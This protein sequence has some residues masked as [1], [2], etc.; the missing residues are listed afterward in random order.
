[1][2]NPVSTRVKRRGR[3]AA[4]GFTLIEV[5]TALFVMGVG[6]TVFVQLYMSSLSISH[7]S[8][9]YSIASQIAE[10]YM[11]ELQINPQQFV[12]P[13]FDDAEVGEL[14]PISLADEDSRLQKV[15]L[16]TV[17][18]ITPGAHER[19]SNL[20]EKFSWT[21]EARI[22]EVDSN[23]VEVRVTINWAHVSRE[24]YFYLTSTV[25]RSVGEGIGL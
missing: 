19:E 10:E 15:A 13:N 18:P 8:T 12:W 20:Y 11:T 6:V 4:S 3:Y 22:H 16:P 21:A 23:F 25:P 2:H 5:L 9:R 7:S 17:M 24:Q 14:L 1:M